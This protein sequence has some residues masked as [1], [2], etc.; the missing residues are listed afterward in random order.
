VTQTLTVVKTLLMI[1]LLSFLAGCKNVQIVSPANNSVS[2]TAPEFRI[3]FKNGVPETFTATINGTVIDRAAFTVEGNDAVAP[4]SL[5]QLKAGDNEFALTAPSSVKSVFHLDQAGPVIHLLGATEGDPRQVTGY[6]SDRGGP[7]SLSINGTAVTLDANGRFNTSVPNTTTH[8][9]LATDVYGHTTQ[10]SFTRLGQRFNPAFAVRINQQGL[11]DSLP[12]A[13]LQIVESLDFNS[14]ITNPISESCSGALIADACANFSVNNVELTP[15]STVAITALS[16]NRLR[17]N[18]HLSRLDLDTT[19]RTYARCKSFLCG[20]NGNIFG[21]LTFSGLTT[22]QNTNISAEF[23]VSVNN[24]QVS[25]QIVNGTLDVDL[26][27]NGL[28][29]DIDFGA[30]EDIPFIGDLMNTVVNGIINGL[31]GVLSS[32]IVNIA[33]GF[34]AGPVSSLINSLI[35]SLLPDNIALP[36]GDTTLNIGFSPQGFATSAGGF[37]LVLASDVGIDARDPDVLPTLG[38][39]FVAGSAPAPYPTQAPGGSNVDLTATLSA[40]LLNQILTEA[41]EGGLLDITLDEDDGFTLGSLLSIPDFPLDLT[42]VED[43]SIVLK[44]AT[45]PMVTVLP[46]TSP[47]GVIRLQVLD[48]TLKVNVDI[49]D[50]RGLQEV[51]TTTIDLRSP[52]DLGITPDNRLTVGIEGTPEVTVQSFRIQ[53]GGLVISSGNASVIKDLINSLAPQLLPIMLESLGGVPI[54][55]IQGFSLQLAGIWNPSASN[56][57]FLSLAGN[58]VSTAAMAT[59]EAPVISAQAVETVYPMF[60]TVTQEQ[61]RS[62]TIALDGFNPEQAPLEFRYRINGGHWTVWKPRSQIQL[63]YLPAGDNQVEVCARTALLKE[64]CTTL[65]VPVPS[66]Q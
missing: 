64:D 59:A 61:R 43:I 24:G 55:S 17:M 21:T 4:V 53:A 38:S 37:D 19:A 44:G 52:F 12:E 62:A 36:V 32:I 56:Q 16:G 10:E 28:Q 7:A 42:G 31:V 35:S 5:G 14:F 66:A 57:A 50:G 41:Y 8:T 48:L 15:G 65:V 30:V 20:G 45:A 25:V 11:A 49:G 2:N 47:D 3:R 9:L 6:L 1:G 34:I 54:P 27:L 40:N 33:D 13:I 51:L 58:L 23:V 63:S 39:L 29:V 26:P 18:L 60:A 46:Q 22:V